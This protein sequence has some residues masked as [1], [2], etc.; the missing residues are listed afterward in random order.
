MIL[1]MQKRNVLRQKFYER[2]LP[3]IFRSEHLSLNISIIY[4]NTVIVKTNFMCSV[5]ACVGKGASDNKIVTRTRCN[6]ESLELKL[7]LN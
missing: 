7:I 6:A 4:Y 2:I 3:S 1:F 5:P